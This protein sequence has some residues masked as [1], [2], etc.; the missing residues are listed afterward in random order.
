MSAESGTSAKV[1]KGVTFSNAFNYTARYKNV[2]KQLTGG[3]GSCDRWL[4]AI[5][6]SEKK[7][8][9]S[10]DFSVQSVFKSATYG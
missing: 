10:A 9:R 3:R 2:G 5:R 7:N 6:S 1:I 8:E 4:F